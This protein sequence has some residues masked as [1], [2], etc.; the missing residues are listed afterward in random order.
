MFLHQ[1]NQLRRIDNINVQELLCS[2]EAQGEVA[3]WGVSR[4]WWVW[5]IYT[6]HFFLRTSS[7]SSAHSWQS[8]I[9]NFLPIFLSLTWKALR[10]QCLRSR[11]ARI[12]QSAGNSLAFFTATY[13]L[14]QG[15]KN[16]QSALQPVLR[17]VSH[18]LIV[19]IKQSHVSQTHSPNKHRKK[20]HQFEDLSWFFIW[21]K[22]RSFSLPQKAQ[23]VKYNIPEHLQ[24]WD[25]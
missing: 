4:L 14:K 22:D 13:C 11:L 16:M 18:C 21:E 17:D 1:S 9:L 2:G 12:L 6:C 7:Q 5:V 15:M 19:T 20:T 25:L 8:Q 24:G 10:L 3:P 23:G